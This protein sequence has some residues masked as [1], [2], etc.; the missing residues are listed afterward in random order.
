MVGPNCGATRS[1]S[2]LPTAFWLHSIRLRP[3]GRGSGGTS[4][5]KNLEGHCVEEK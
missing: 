1:Q 2:A 5:S 4:L 3:L